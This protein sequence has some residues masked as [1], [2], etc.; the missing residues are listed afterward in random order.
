MHLSARLKATAH[1]QELLHLFLKK[2][3]IIFPNGCQGKPHPISSSSSEGLLSPREKLVFWSSLPLHEDI[4][5]AFT[6]QPAPAVGHGRKSISAPGNLGEL[7]Q[8]HLCCS[9][10]QFP[11]MQ[12]KKTCP[13]CSHGWGKHKCD[14]GHEKPGQRKEVLRLPMSTSD[15]T[16]LPGVGGPEGGEGAIPV[17]TELGD[18]RREQHTKTERRGYRSSSWLQIKDTIGRGEQSFDF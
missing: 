16:V 5:S 17:S 11:H 9:N 4:Q 18:G 8:V 7:G 3:P 6:P 15:V 10:L 1:P 12:H 2:Y 13:V 14:N